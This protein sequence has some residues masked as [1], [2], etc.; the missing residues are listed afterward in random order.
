[1]NYLIPAFL[2]LFPVFSPAQQGQALSSFSGRLENSGISLEWVT[3]AGSFCQ[4]LKLFHSTDSFIFSEIYEYPGICGSSNSPEKYTYFHKP[5]SQNGPQYYYLDLGPS[6]ITETIRVD[7]WFAGPENLI[8]FPNPATEFSQI[9]LLPG[10]NFPATISITDP[11][12]K[13]LFNYA[14]SEPGEIYLLK[15]EVGTGL[16]FIRV[17]DSKGKSFSRKLIF[18]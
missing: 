12:G 14:V 2:I 17:S 9:K 8:L 11:T 7:F 1:M 5:G 15:D 6:G 10:F 16:F 13:T 3:R 18:N 4:G